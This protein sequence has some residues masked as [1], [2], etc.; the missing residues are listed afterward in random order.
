[1]FKVNNKGTRIRKVN[2]K[3]NKNDTI[4]VVLISLLLN[5]NTFDFLYSVYIVVFDQL[6]GW[7][8]C[9]LFWRFV[10]AGI[11]LGKFPTYEET[12]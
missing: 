5:L 3:V 4:D 12:W 9:L 7:V 2:Y 6:I 11:N 1:M 8:C 10:P